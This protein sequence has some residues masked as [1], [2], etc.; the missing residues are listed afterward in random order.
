METKRQYGQAD[1]ADNAQTNTAN[2][3]TN[4]DTQQHNG[5]LI[6][7]I[8]DITTPKIRPSPK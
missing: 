7:N 8:V 1:T 3:R 2:L 4:Q 5:N 6:K